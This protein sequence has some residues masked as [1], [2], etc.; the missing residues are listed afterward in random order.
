MTAKVQAIPSI[1]G[2]ADKTIAVREC[3]NFYECYT[4]AV[5]PFAKLAK[6][7][8]QGTTTTCTRA[9]RRGTCTTTL[10]R[11]WTLQGCLSPVLCSLWSTA[12]ER[13]SDIELAK[14]VSAY[15]CKTSLRNIEV[16]ADEG[17]FSGHVTPATQVLHELYGMA[18]CFGSEEH[19]LRVPRQAEPRETL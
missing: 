10:H 4:R 17:D 3:H 9:T 1:R 8:R 5:E 19:T 6:I 13:A 15:K 7:C 16:A 18:R 14:T 12:A 2:N 11:L